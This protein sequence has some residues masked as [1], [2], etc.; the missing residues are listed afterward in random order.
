MSSPAPFR[1]FRGSTL[2]L[3]TISFLC[4]WCTLLFEGWPEHWVNVLYA[5]V[6]GIH[7]GNTYSG[8]WEDGKD[9]DFYQTPKY[10]DFLYFLCIMVGQSQGLES[11][12]EIESYSIVSGSVVF[13]SCLDFFSCKM[14][15]AVIT[16]H[17]YHIAW[18]RRWPWEPQHR[19]S[20]WPGFTAVNR[21]TWNLGRGGLQPP[22]MSFLHH[23]G[24]SENTS[25]KQNICDHKPGRAEP[26]LKWGFRAWSRVF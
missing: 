11:R 12:L 4:C 22:E 26:I 10:D 18:M 17:G 15:L 7:R 14:G 2:L 3:V 1:S 24:D 19:G 23:T 9:N 5:W 13:S 16:P 20:T 25:P 21:Y 8:T 6:R